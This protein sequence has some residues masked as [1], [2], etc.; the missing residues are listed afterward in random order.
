MLQAMGNEVEEQDDK[1]GPRTNQATTRGYADGPGEA[2]HCQR[3]QWEEESVFRLFWFSILSI[4]LTS[5]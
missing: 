1:E 3:R 4:I 5:A 2:N